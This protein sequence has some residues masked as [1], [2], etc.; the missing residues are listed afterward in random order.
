MKTLISLLR[1]I[2][3]TGH[4][5]IKMADLSN[6]YTE[7]GF[8]D[9]ETYIQSGN[10]IFSCESDLKET[11]LTAIIEEGIS[12]KFK[13][14]ISVMLR[15]TEEMKNI[16]KVNHFLTKENFDPAKMAVIFLNKAPGNTEV[17]I[18]PSPG[19]LPD[20]FLIHGREIFIYCPNGFARTRLY[21]NFFEKKNDVIGTTRN[22]KTVTTL[23]NIAEK[24][25]YWRSICSYLLSLCPI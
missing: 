23:L 4:N 19:S 10:V 8:A 14:M 11:E 1:G 3:M 18:V 9:V 7:L 22:W 5:S 6:L 13:Y 21:S 25:E 12:E 15:N 2:N 20:Q 17:Q 16:T 24:R